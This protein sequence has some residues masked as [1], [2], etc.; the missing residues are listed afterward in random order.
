MYESPYF[1]FSN[2]KAPEAKG[3]CR[4]SIIASITLNSR[5]NFYLS[6]N[7]LSFENCSSFS[8]MLKGASRA[9]EPSSSLIKSDMFKKSKTF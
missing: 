1:K 9:F 7:S 2:L 3:T 5:M 8:A 4:Y 6:F